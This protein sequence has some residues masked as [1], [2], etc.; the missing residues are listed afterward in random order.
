M[1]IILL[2]A[3]AWAAAGAVPA[4]EP[5]RD[6]FNGKDLDGWVVEGPQKDK[7]GMPI[8]SVREQAIHCTGKAFGFL[9]YDQ[10]QFGDFVL[11]VEFRM[12]GKCNS[13]IGIRTPPYDPRDSEKTR[14][15]YAAYEVQILDDA[16]KPPHKG[17]SGSLYR[18]L[19]PKKNAVKP[20]GEW[21]LLEIRCTGP[22]ISITLNGEQILD[23]DQRRLDDLDASER[24][25][26]ISAPKDKPLKGYI[27]L[28]S[29]SNAI[30]FRSVRIKEQ[31]S[32]PA[33]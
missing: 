3:V 25:A 21:N 15:S 2:T 29:H 8:W 16:G 32:P 1:R 12:S 27:C 6:L 30:E 28:Q 24:P 20:A 19:A 10:Q 33:R 9:R 4:D 5:F 7:D 18:Y 13:G 31:K 11:Q 17:G 23:A 26:G 22:C 14:P